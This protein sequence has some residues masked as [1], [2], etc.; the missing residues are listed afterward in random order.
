MFA[1]LATALFPFVELKST[2]FHI[3]T[4][5]EKLCGTCVTVAKHFDQKPALIQCVLNLNKNI[6]LSSFSFFLSFLVWTLELTHCRCEGTFCTWCHSVTHTLSRTPL[7]EG[8]THRKDYPTTHN[9]H[10]RQTSMPAAGFESA[11]TASE[12]PHTHFLDCASVSWLN[13]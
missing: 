2:G 13:L 1:I 12:R 7:D 11:I 6:C 8:S 4:L 10:K 5:S 3:K 9:T